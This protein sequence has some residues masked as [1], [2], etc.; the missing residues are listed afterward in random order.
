MEGSETNAQFTGTG[1]CRDWERALVMWVLTW[2]CKRDRVTWARGLN[3]AWLSTA[4][5]PGSQSV[6]HEDRLAPSCMPALSLCYSSSCPELSPTLI[7]SP[8]TAPGSGPYPG[9]WNLEPRNRSDKSRNKHRLSSVPKRNNGSSDVFTIRKLT[10]G[11][12]A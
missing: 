1:G 7:P 5:L 10:L 11:H 4:Q 6:L 8:L 3:M 12:K 9:I 2:S